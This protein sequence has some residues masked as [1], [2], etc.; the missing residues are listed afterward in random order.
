MMNNQYRT[1]PATCARD[2]RWNFRVSAHTDALVHRAAAVVGVS[3][4]EFVVGDAVAR[5][6]SVL[7]E[8]QD[9]TL[10]PEEFSRF[11]EA[12]DAAPVAI[13]ALVDL[14]SRRS[15]IPTD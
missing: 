6:R 11:V 8:H 7:A 3:K 10:S 13:P 12:L 15:R 14:F 5:A 4:T 1:E 2:H 9:V